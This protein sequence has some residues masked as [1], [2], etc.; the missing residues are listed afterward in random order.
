MPVFSGMGFIAFL[1]RSCSAIVIMR[2][3]K[4]ISVP[5]LDRTDIHIEVPH[6]D[7]EKPSDGNAI[8]GQECGLR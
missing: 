5:L 7:Y 8:L 1:T 2:N 6:V 3:R 4:R